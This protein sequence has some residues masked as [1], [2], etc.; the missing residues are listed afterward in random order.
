MNNR[1]E[2]RQCLCTEYGAPRV[3]GPS[4]YFLDN[5]RVNIGRSSQKSDHKELMLL[6]LN[7]LE[8]ER[9]V[10]VENEDIF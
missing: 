10:L 4:N 9:P 2:V 3:A 6:S 1:V 8:R 7:R 5:P